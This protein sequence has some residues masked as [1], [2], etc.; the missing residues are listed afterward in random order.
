MA[1][2]SDGLPPL[3]RGVTRRAFA[4][5]TLAGGFGVTAARGDEPAS[6]ASAPSEDLAEILSRARAANLT[7][8]RSSENEHFLGVGDAPNDYRIR[9]LRICRDLAAAYLKHFREKGFTLDLP[10]RKLPVITLKDKRSYKAFVGE[11]PGEDVGGHYDLESNALVIFDFRPDRKELAAVAPERLNTFTLVHESIH[12]L[13]FNTGLLQRGG[14]VPLCISEG[15]AMY[16]E[17]W[18]PPPRRSVMGAVNKTRLKV[19]TDHLAERKEPIPLDRLLTDDELCANAETEQLAYAQSCLL[20][21]FLMSRPVIP[22]FRAY[23][24]AIQGR[25]DASKRLDDLK[26]HVGDPVELERALRRY[27]ARVS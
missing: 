5:G 1:D 18:Q 23:L 22:K 16:G 26:A 25:R 8:F 10:A 7:A 17:M 14:D 15:L 3:R 24:N 2:S 4:I 13:T 20:V 12:Q 27:Q 19:L 21:H 9:A 6:K 11:A